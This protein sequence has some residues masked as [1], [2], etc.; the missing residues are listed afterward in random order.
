MIRAFLAQLGALWTRVRAQISRVL[1][2]VDYGLSF[3][4]KNSQIVE[5]WPQGEMKL[6][7][8]I[9]IFIHYDGQGA[10]GDHTQHYVRSLKAA[11]FSV[12]FVTN[13]NKLRRDAMATLQT[14]C[15]G[16]IVR[17]NIGYDFGAMREGLAYLN[18]PRADT[19]MVVL[20]NDSIYGP[21]GPL[22]DMIS[23]MDLNKADFWGATD[24]WQQRYHIQSYFL[25]VGRK[26]LES[27]AWKDFWAEVRPVKSKTWVVSRYEL[28]LSQRMVR[29]GLRLAA[30][31]RYQDLINNVNAAWLMEP[32]KEGP[33]TA[34]PMVQMRYIHAHRIRH[35]VATRTPLN[36]T[37]DLWRQLLQAGFPFLKRELMRDNP[38]FVA[39]LID[40]RDEVR[41]Q[42]GEVPEAIEAD[43][44]R[45]MR[46]RVP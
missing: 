5:V 46:N 42:F 31:W 41:K 44:R 9:V 19:E 43:L 21:L 8:R 38:T 39:D 33:Q 14:L 20:A 28:G 26:V 2:Y 34:E 1:A 35:N 27:K 18:L 12:V 10:L 24:S 6:G 4:R 30:V 45:V 37:S 15:A 11:G 7:P 13:S 29:G 17:R 32:R 36:P 16:V 23:R 40:W 22:D 3:L 25:A